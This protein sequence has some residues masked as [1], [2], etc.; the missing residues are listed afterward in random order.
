MAQ[1]S[2]NWDDAVFRSAKE[3]RKQAMYYLKLNKNAMEAETKP[4][5]P[6]QFLAI[7]NAFLISQKLGKI[8]LGEITENI[9]VNTTIKE[10]E[11]FHT[12]MELLDELARAK[13]KVNDT[14]IH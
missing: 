13:S 5:P 10:A 14:A 11:A 2:M 6:S 4:F 7:S 9:N 8:A 12:A 3:L 1:K